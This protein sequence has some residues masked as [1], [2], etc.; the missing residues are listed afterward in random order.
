MG[1]QQNTRSSRGKYQETQRQGSKNYLIAEAK[2]IITS[3]SSLKD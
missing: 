3:D 2:R 1:V